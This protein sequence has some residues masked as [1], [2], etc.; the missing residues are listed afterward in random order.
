MPEWSKKYRNMALIICALAFFFTYFAARN[1]LVYGLAMLLA[2]GYAY[3]VVR[4]NFIGTTSY[5]IFD[6]AVLG[7]YC[8]Q[9]FRALTHSEQSRFRRLRPWVEILI[10]WPVIMF[11]VPFQDLLIRVVGLR[12]NIYMLP[13]LFIGTRMQ[14]DERYQLALWLA[15]LN[16]VAFAFALA[17]Y[18]YGVPTFYPRNEMT[19]II[20]AS[21]VFI[22]MDVLRIP[23]TFTSAHAYAGTMVMT[24]PFLVGAL[25]QKTRRDWHKPLLTAAVVA[26]LLG[27]FMSATRLNFIVAS[28]LVT[29][30]VFSLRSRFAYAFGWLIII[31]GIAWFVS[32]EQRLQRFTQLQDTK[33]ISLRI[34]GSVNMGFFELLSTHPFGNGMGGGGT[35]I[36]AFLQGRISSPI[37][38]EN[39]YARILLEQGVI[40]LVIWI[41][42]LA[43]LFTRR[44]TEEA[45]PWLLGR[46]LAWCACLAFFASSIAGVGLL[47]SVPQTAL[48]ML[49]MGWLGAPQPSEQPHF[50]PVP[51][52]RSEYLLRGRLPAR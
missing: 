43:W 22:S 17:E 19:T 10:A 11:F 4:S 16:L 14:P 21:T 8:A 51:P 27:V 6:S 52:Y 2:V 48:V 13:F 30:A 20:Y 15:G 39:E 9:L 37:S 49:C 47:V 32:S 35:S 44:F 28:L 23:A 34:A 31:F 1:S 42:F 33:M 40:G 5:F 26:A 38:M 18:V 25:V 24:I 12:A 36:P 45:D 7:F 29:V 3:G 50:E 46:R 41:A